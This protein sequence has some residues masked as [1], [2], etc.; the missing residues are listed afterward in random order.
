VEV[1]VVEGVEVEIEVLVEVGVSV[2]LVEVGVGVGVE[3]EVLLELL[4]LVLEGVTVLVGTDTVSLELE[5]LSSISKTT[6]LALEPLEAVTTQP[7]APPA[8]VKTSGALISFTPMVEGSIRQGKPLQ[9]SPSHSISIPNSGL[10][11]RKGV[12]GSR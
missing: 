11:S 1:E 2:V 8:P 4:E 5:P 6:I 10:T 7:V 12:V 3:V 9:S